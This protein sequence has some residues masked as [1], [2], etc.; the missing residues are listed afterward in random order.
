MAP[1][2][3]GETEQ[4]TALNRGVDGSVSGGTQST[5][6]E[7]KT[8]QETAMKIDSTTEGIIHSH[9]NT[10]DYDTAPGYNNKTSGDHTAVERGIPNMVTRKGTT[11]VVEKVNGQYRIRTVQGKLTRSERR[12]TRLRLNKFQ[13]VGRN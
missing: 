5:G 8:G 7:N 10:M 9:P 1:S 3:D 6:T 2:L 12:K 11:I 4:G 13:K